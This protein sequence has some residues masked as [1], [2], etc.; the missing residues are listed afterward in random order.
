MLP[1][2]VPGNAWVNVAR[3]RAHNNARR[4]C[5]AHRGVYRL[6]RKR[7]CYA[8]AAAEMGVNDSPIRCDITG[9]VTK[10]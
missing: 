6:A 8:C 3:P 2:Q 7:R 10:F 9:Y 5:K 1:M 4:R